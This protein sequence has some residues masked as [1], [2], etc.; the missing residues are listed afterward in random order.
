M[1]K[2]EF[3]QALKKIWYF[4]WESD[5]AWSWV[6]N[7]LLAFIIIKFIVYPGLGFAFQT[8]HPIVAV[9]SGSMEHDGSFDQWW[10]S[11][12]EWY[13][14]KGITKEQFKEFSFKNGFNRGDIMVLRGKKP[15]DMKIGDV[16]VYHGRLPDPII[17]RVVDVSIEDN[18]YYFQTKGDHNTNP[19]QQLVNQNYIVGYAKY[20]KASKAVLR[21]PYLGYIKIIFVELIGMPYCKITNN[22]FPCRG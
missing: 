9:V 16:I 13:L 22:F 8:T 15:D 7:I 18:A 3:K 2:K 4:I 21:I 11:Q 5:S 19:D 20:Q 6:V 12:D 10:G 1:D 14:S 17:H